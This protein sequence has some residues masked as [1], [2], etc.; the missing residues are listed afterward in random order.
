M[1]RGHSGEWARAAGFALAVALAG[2][3][4]GTET[5]GP[6]GSEDGLPPIGARPTRVHSLPLT[7]VNRLSSP[8]DVIS[9]PVP[10][11]PAAQARRRASLHSYL[12]QEFLGAYERLG[13]KDPRSYFDARQ[14]LEAYVRLLERPDENGDDWVDAW[15]HADQALKHGCNDPLVCFVFARLSR[16]ECQ[17]PNKARVDKAYKDA[18]EGMREPGYSATLRA[19]VFL[20]AGEN[21][22]VIVT[23][24]PGTRVVTLAARQSAPVLFDQA[25]ALVPEAARECRGDPIR[26]SAGHRLLAALADGM[27]S[28]DD[29]RVA[30]EKIMAKLDEEKDK[31]KTAAD[32]L[33]G[34]VFNHMAWATRGRASAAALKNETWDAFESYLTQAA[35]FVERAWQ[36]DPDSADA[37]RLM[38]DVECGQ[39]KGRERMEM[40][41]ERAM[42]LDGDDYEACLLKLTYLEPGWYGSAADMLAFGREC[43]RTGNWEGRLPF[44]L[45]EA[46]Q[47]LAGVE[48]SEPRRER[49]GNRRPDRS[50]FAQP[51]VWDDL[52]AVYEPYLAKHPDARYERSVYARMAALGGHYTEAVRLFKE[53]GPDNWWRTVFRGRDAEYRMLKQEAEDAVAAGEPVAAA[54]AK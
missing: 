19:R 26:V 36:A 37:A 3:T 44:V 33:T 28:V 14:A 32:L 11:D 8:A 51:R 31:N 42:R 27:A 34:H 41:F 46:H 6:V 1:P 23:V 15:K 9:A 7:D 30:R 18:V 4:S 12:V 22:A 21:A 54:P 49:P 24:T 29:R 13:R 16:H 45:A 53:L 5:A 2:C 25:L 35:N 17:T 10:Q 50:Y 47:R 48:W 40:W 43:L 52:R 38:I 39:G 20:R